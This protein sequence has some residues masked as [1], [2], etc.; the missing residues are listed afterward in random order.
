LL[1]TNYIPE[2]GTLMEKL[3]LE[4][5]AQKD[6]DGVH[7]AGMDILRTFR[8]AC[9]IPKAKHLLPILYEYNPCS[10]CRES[11][12][13]FMSGHRMLT[14]E[15]LEECRFDSSYEIRR[16]AEKRLK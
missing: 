12:L 5:V 4:L 8:N 15:I 6:W 10:F 9:G 14:K 11:A 1:A 2:D 7:A 13:R 16:F 3:L